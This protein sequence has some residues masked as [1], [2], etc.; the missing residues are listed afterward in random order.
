MTRIV[1][2][3]SGSAIT[4]AAIPWLAER[5]GAEIVTVTVDLGQGEELAAIRE[6]ALS[7]GAVRAHVIDAREQ[8]IREFLVP[9]LQAGALREGH[10][11]RLPLVVTRLAEIARME[12]AS[13]IAHCA[14]GA[15]DGAVITM[16]AS[17]VDPA[18]Q[19]IAVAGESGLTELEIRSLLRR[20][21][22]HSAPDTGVRA[23]ASLWGRRVE[24]AEG[25]AVGEEAFTLTRAAEECP[26][27]PAL[28]DIE[29]IGGVP[30]RVNGVEMSMVEMIESLETIAGAHGV[31]RS[32]AADAAL[33]MP[34]AHVLSLAHTAL[35]AKVL[36]EDLARIKALLAVAYGNAM[37]DGRWFSDLRHGI[38]SF[39]RL[40]QPR[41][42][43]AVRLRLL[44][45]QCT[46]LT[47]EPRR[48]TGM[49]AQAVA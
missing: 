43:G 16:L 5:Y 20:H 19:V 9:V 49:P 21:G 23:H 15:D 42:S 34:A 14:L 11:L 47:C 25:R 41:V 39:A 7:L 8:L 33:E 24:A 45:G 40:I 1:L 29:F 46:V 35:E 4:S 36:G 22:V 17:G 18:L 26:D 6:R 2:G 48:G 12:T 13:A 38:Q 37:R 32:V 3:Y 30:V 28:L 10:A 44:K 27:D 31:G